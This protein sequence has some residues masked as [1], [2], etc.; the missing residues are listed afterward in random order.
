MKFAFCVFKYFA[1]GGISRDM[2]R[3]ARMS[4]ARGHSVRV[5][6]LSWEGPPMDGVDVVVAPVT[7]L[8]R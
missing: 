6:T 2:E 3:I 8:T 1:F 4:L 5:Y 7:G